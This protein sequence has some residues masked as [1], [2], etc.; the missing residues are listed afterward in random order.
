MLICSNENIKV[1]IGF[2]IANSEG[3]KLL[4]VKL[5]WKLNFDDRISDICKT[6]NGK[7]NA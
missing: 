2:E 3:E 1:K 6:V 7:L 4:G 5:D